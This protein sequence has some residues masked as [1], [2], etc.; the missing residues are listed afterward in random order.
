MHPEFQEAAWLSRI[1]VVLVS[2]SH[3][4]NVGAC[5]RALKT[6]GL[7]QLWLVSPRREGV[8]TDPEALALAS[9]ATDVLANARMVQSLP[10][11]LAGCVWTVATS[12][13]ER[14]LGP[15]LL[16]APEA[17]AGLLQQLQAA[18]FTR[19]VALVFGCERTG[20]SNDELLRA[21]V[22]AMIPANPAYASLNLSQAVQLLCWEVRKGVLAAC[23]VRQTTAP[24]PSSADTAQAVDSLA[25]ERLFDHF[26]QA[27]TAVDFLHPDKPKRLVPRM[28]RILQ[29]A[30]LEQ[31]EVD[32][33]HGFLSDVVRVSQGRWYR[34]EWEAL[35]TAV[36]QAQARYGEAGDAGVPEK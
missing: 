25:I 10:D 29:K 34:A 28:R 20:L 16:D 21:D 15:P 31:E 33:L 23:A 7:S 22:H 26:L 1:R 9:G 13:R 6:M 19:D 14:E 12:S 5:A 8:L 2:P 35:A 36:R 30:R 32:L 3:A 11:A 24:G 4:G 27:M 17:V 18:T